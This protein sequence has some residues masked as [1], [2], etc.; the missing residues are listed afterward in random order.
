ME[1]EKL[2]EEIYAL[3]NHTT[4]YGTNYLEWPL[5]TATKPPM[6]LNESKLF[7]TIYFECKLKPLFEQVMREEHLQEMSKPSSQTLGNLCAN[8]LERRRQIDNNWQSENSLS[9]VVNS[10]IKDGC[11]TNENLKPN[12]SEEE[13]LAPNKFEAFIENVLRVIKSK[14]QYI[15]PNNS[16]VF[17]TL[18]RLFKDHFRPS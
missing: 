18:R 15:L 3:S 9:E 12:Y 10:S 11:G 14:F 7:E 17:T 5:D 6:Y 16:Q 1:L 8:K 2:F 13:K 4:E